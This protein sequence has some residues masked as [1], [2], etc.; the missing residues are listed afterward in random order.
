MFTIGAKTFY[1][2]EQLG[3]DNDVDKSPQAE[4]A[5]GQE[6]EGDLGDL[7]DQS[8]Q[9]YHLMRTSGKVPAGFL[10]Y[11]TSSLNKQGYK[12]VLVSEQGA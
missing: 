1:I 5:D 3:Q 12:V 6:Q 2:E 7:G 10:H 8:H 4:D 11:L 9:H